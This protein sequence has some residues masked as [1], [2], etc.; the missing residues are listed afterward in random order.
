MLIIVDLQ[1]TPYLKINNNKHVGE[2]ATFIYI[3]EFM[4]VFNGS[5]KDIYSNTYDTKR[6]ES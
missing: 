2:Q 5:S 3:M 4:Q 1:I 6:L